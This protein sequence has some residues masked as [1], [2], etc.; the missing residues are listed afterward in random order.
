MAH[1]LSTTLSPVHDEVMTPPPSPRH[2]PQ[3]DDVLNGV[4]PHPYTLDEFKAYLVKNHCSEFLDFILDVRDYNEKYISSLPVPGSIHQQ[5]QEEEGEAEAAAEWLLTVWQRIISVYIL[6]GSSREMN[7]SGE[8]RDKLLQ[9]ADERV[10][11]SPCS[12]EEAIKGIYE[13]FRA[14]IFIAFLIDPSP[15][16]G[17]SVMVTTATA[18]SYLSPRRF[19]PEVSTFSSS[20]SSSSSRHESPSTLIPYDNDFSGYSTE[21]SVLSSSNEMNWRVI[22][23]HSKSAEDSSPVQ[24]DVTPT[25]EMRGKVKMTWRSRARLIVKKLMRPTGKQF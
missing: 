17:G 13:S 23:T 5:Q 21:D 2:W 10:P 12:I 22:V 4:S 3:F 11:P 20:S 15:A 18:G 16:P 6:P 9:Y 25:I 14:S 19:E 8:E 24:W 7:L 1:Y